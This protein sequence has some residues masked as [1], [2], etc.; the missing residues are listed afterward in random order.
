MKHLTIISLLI[1]LI[2]FSSTSSAQ[3]KKDNLIIVSLTDSTKVYEK[4]T[5][6]LKAEGYKLEKRLTNS[7]FVHTKAK[8]IGRYGNTLCFYSFKIAGN[9]ISI[10][11]QWHF[12]YSQNGKILNDKSSFLPGWNEMDRL[13]KLLGTVTYAKK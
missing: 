4:V 5:G 11:G 12:D 9:T 7:E 2:A 8:T 10:S 1:S 6:L 13:A 3:E